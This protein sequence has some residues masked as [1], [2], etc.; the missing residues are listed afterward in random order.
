MKIKRKISVL[1]TGVSLFALT[2]SA[3]AV[4]LYCNALGS[5]SN[6]SVNC[7]DSGWCGVAYDEET[8]LST[9]TC[10]NGDVTI[11]GCIAGP[12]IQ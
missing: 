6:T 8:N 12:G 5:C 10:G 4:D 7:G 9:I 11:V 1:L 2:F 3:N